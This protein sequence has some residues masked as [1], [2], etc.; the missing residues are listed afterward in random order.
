MAARIHNLNSLTKAEMAKMPK[1]KIHTP[2]N[3]D[4]S[5][6]II[7]FEVQGYTP[8]RVVQRLHDKH[9]VASV[10]PGFYN[11]LLARVA[12]SL[13][14]LEVDVERTVQAIAAL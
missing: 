14:T 10:V 5:A 12:P 1:V 13:L 4:L 6:G 7:T 8:E 9:I 3:V 2:R 11:P